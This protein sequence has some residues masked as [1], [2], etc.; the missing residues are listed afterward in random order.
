MAKKW[1]GVLE[2]ADEVI[3][4]HISYGGYNFRHGKVGKVLSAS[5]KGFSARSLLKELID[6]VEGNLRTRK[7]SAEIKLGVSKSN[8]R[9]ES[10]KE[11]HQKRKSERDLEH[12]IA[13]IAGRNDQ[14]WKWWNQ[15]P[16]ASGF[17][18]HRSDRTRA[19][20]LPAEVRLTPATTD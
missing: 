11:E 17:L 8:W 2:G 10:P 5:P 16:I 9:E 7:E 3:N 15:M 6:T 18:E 13:N 12:M 19:I 4:R 20:D 14:Y 1:V